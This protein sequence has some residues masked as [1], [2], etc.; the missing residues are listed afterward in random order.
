MSTYL[1]SAFGVIFFSVLISFL[2]PEGKLN[3]IICSVIKIVCIA[4]LIQ[5][6][7]GIFL[8]LENQENLIDFNYVSQ[9]Y[10]QNQ[11]VEL[12]K[13]LQEKFNVD[14]SCNVVIN[15]DESNFYLEKTQIFT[16]N[17]DEQTN[18]KIYEYLQSLGY[19]NIS[20]NEQ[21]D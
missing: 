16:F 21:I 4:V 10:S 3:K 20:I 7:T 1:L 18:N 2:V 5:P 15:Y 17:V 19:I 11:S 12:Q 13:I 8:P 9:T 14:C 6:I